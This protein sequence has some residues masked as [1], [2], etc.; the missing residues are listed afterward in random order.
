MA[1]TVGSA[2]PPGV[3]LDFGPVGEAGQR[4]GAGSVGQRNGC[5]VVFRTRHVNAPADRADG[6]LSTDRRRRAKPPL[7]RSHCASS[8]A[9]WVR[10]NRAEARERE[11]VSDS[12]FRA[13]ETR[14]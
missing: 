3:Y 4:I 12:P 13:A 7:K 2:R 5:R 1:S 6:S 8:M 10:T 11:A 9:A 14:T